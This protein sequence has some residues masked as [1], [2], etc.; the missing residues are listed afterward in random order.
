MV[1]VYLG[2]GFECYTDVNMTQRDAIDRGFEKNADQSD[3]ESSMVVKG[4]II[5]AL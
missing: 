2:C 1:L 3:L 5:L 4:G